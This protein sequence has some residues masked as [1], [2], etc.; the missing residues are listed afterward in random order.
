MKH[1][2][3]MF[4]VYVILSNIVRC[5]VIITLCYTHTHDIYI[6]SSFVEIYNKKITIIRVNINSNSNNNNN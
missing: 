2:I 5:Y 1:Y 6:C 3:Q 4:Y